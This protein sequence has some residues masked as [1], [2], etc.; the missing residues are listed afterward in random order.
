MFT[1]SVIFVTI[2]TLVLMMFFLL[3]YYNC[4]I[5]WKLAGNWIVF[6]ASWTKMLGNKI[7]APL[8]KLEIIQ[9]HSSF[10][11]EGNPYI[12]YYPVSSNKLYSANETN[13][14]I[15]SFK[16]VTFFCNFSCA[17]WHNTFSLLAGVTQRIM[18]NQ[19]LCNNAFHYWTK[20][21]KILHVLDPMHIEKSWFC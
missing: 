15:I 17:S 10:P 13:F 11:W 14:V 12:K 21:F 1:D 4:E 2:L 8:T 20:S 9:W 6:C 3:L 18:S 16:T 19:T 5:F 7:C